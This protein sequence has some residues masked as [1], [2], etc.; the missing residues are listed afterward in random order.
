M[1]LRHQMKMVCHEHGSHRRHLVTAAGALQQLQKLNSIS[2]VSEDLLP[3]IA[4]GAEMIDGILKSIRNGRAI[5]SLLTAAR[6]MS[7]ILVVAQFERLS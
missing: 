5:P 6:K 4:P 7:K 2:I 3:L 1:G